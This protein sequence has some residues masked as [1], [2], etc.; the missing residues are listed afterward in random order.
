MEA[1][2]VGPQKLGRGLRLEAT[3]TPKASELADG[4]EGVGGEGGGSGTP[5]VTPP[6]KACGHM[7]PHWGNKVQEEGARGRMLARVSPPRTAGSTSGGPSVPPSLLGDPV[8]LPVPWPW[9]PRC[10]PD[11]PDVPDLPDLPKLQSALT[12]DD[13]VLIKRKSQQ[14]FI[15]DNHKIE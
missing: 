2:S 9:L 7:A 10:G 1:G 14:C 4:A 6:R 12:R 5:L 13:F 3:E 15:L 11:L 8:P